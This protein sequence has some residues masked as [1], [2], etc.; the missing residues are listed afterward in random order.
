M[1]ER[2]KIVVKGG[3]MIMSKREGVRGGNR[4]VEEEEY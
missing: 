2:E 1:R 3:R 4:S